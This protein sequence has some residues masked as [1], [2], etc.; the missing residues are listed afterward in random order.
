ML[1]S[2]KV[3]SMLLAVVMMLTLGCIVV[4]AKE[5]IECSGFV[6]YGTEYYSDLEPI[7]YNSQLQ[8]L[9]EV[10]LFTVKENTVSLNGEI[11]NDD[12]DIVYQIDSVGELYKSTSIKA[13]ATNAFVAMMSKGDNY[14]ILNF[15]IEERANGEDLLP[16]NSYLDNSSVIRLSI[17]D[18]ESNKIFYF[19]GAFP[20]EIRYDAIEKNVIATNKQPDLNGK[21]FSSK[22]QV[23][24]DEIFDS[25]SW[26]FG[27]RKDTENNE[28]MIADYNY[29]LRAN[30]PVTGV[31]VNVFTSLGDWASVNNPSNQFVGYY[32]STN[33]QGGTNNKVTYIIVW[34]YLFNRPNNFTANI[35]TVTGGETAIKITK[36]AE[37][38]YYPASDQITLTNTFAPFRMRYADV[39]MGIPSSGEI[40][41][42]VT[43]SMRANSSTVTVNWKNIIGLLPYG[44]QI[45]SAVSWLNTVTYQTESTGTPSYS[46][47]D[48]AN[49]QRST[50]GKLVRGHKM[51]SNNRDL[52]KDGDHMT[53]TYTICQPADLTRY[54]RS[55]KLMSNYVFGIYERHPVTLLYSSQVLYVDQNREA[56]Y[57]VIQ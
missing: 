41:T 10:N 17:R 26:R 48:T 21:T 19:E 37:Y 12:E 13:K 8:Y 23:T 34:E 29:L 7:E 4:L 38:T 55:N 6:V 43:D 32:A 24:E 31:P 53:L 49:G 27:Y 22:K 40:L 30:T 36:V 20:S 56:T 52:Y 1:K 33:Q 45:N 50:Y 15:T 9:L 42:K 25:E 47:Q 14:T 51:S 54:I 57:S 16:V 5:E 39:Q 11:K 18:D 2:K 3:I 28:V 35:R 46:Y 44:T